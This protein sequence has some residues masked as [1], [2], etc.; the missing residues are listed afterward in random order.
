MP[1]VL[2]RDGFRF[3]IYQGDAEHGPAHVH[4]VK[5][6]TE[7]V[8]LLAPVAVREVKGM[9]RADIRA[10]VRIVEDYNAELL[11]AWE[12]IMSDSTRTTATTK[13]Q[14]PTRRLTDAEIDA[15]IPAARA[16]QRLAE[17]AG[18]R[19]S[20]A[21]YDAASGRIVVEL[22]NGAALAFPAHVVRGLERSSAAQ[23]AALE[24]SPGG[25]GIIWDSLDVDVSVP[26]LL[27]SMFGREAASVLGT[28]GGRATSDA[29]R[30]AARANGKKGGRPPK[31]KSRRAVARRNAA[32]K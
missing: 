20:S 24:V 29:K 21:T 8:I 9:A 22:T 14:L 15:Q 32:R 30:E 11:A 1:T 18:L 19:A 16:R 5:A 3:L 12:R 7:V 31:A 2:R 25:S 6:G 26:G 17:K 13:R 4:A 28:A 27:A 10:A 23:R